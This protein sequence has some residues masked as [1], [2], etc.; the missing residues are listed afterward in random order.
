M[1]F[2]DHFILF[3]ITVILYLF[4]EGHKCRLTTFPNRFFNDVSM[5]CYF[6]CSAIT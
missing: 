2:L 1:Y 3:Y 6:H 5:F 4:A